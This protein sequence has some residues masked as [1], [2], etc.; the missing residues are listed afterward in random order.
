M[1]GR[2]LSEDSKGLA[3]GM[4]RYNYVE[5]R[6]LNY[7]DPDGRVGLP[8]ALI[9]GLIGAASGVAGALVQGNTNVGILAASA[10]TGFVAGA[11]AGS[12]AGLIAGAV[13]NIGANLL[14]Q[15]MGG[16]TNASDFN[17]A[18]AL[19]SGVSGTASAAMGL[20][21]GLTSSLTAGGGLATS[22]LDVL[23]GAVGA[24][25]TQNSCPKK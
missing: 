25:Q 8:G 12:G 13:A 5:N 15:V 2:W 18:S 19:I 7:I 6:P 10:G 1:N 17:V 24:N 3:G 21:P 23:A 20:L 11:I 16:A 14:G 4:N 22:S 9:G